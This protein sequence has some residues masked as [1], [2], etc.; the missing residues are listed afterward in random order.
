MKLWG[1]VAISEEDE[2]ING[3]E[4]DKVGRDEE[5]VDS[6]EVRKEVEKEKEVYN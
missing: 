2:V 5:R 6:E 4:V 1:L 3:R